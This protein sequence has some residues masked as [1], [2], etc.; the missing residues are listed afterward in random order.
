MIDGYYPVPYCDKD[1][2]SQQGYASGQVTDAVPSLTLTLVTAMDD[3]TIYDVQ[4]G[5]QYIGYAAGV[6]GTPTYHFSSVIGA[7]FIRIDGV[8]SEVGAN[9]VISHKED[10]SAACVPC[11][12]SFTNGATDTI[13]VTFTQCH[14]DADVANVKAWIMS[15]RKTN[16]TTFT[17]V[18]QPAAN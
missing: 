7:S 4:V 18:N 16:I 13:N 14:L 11:A 3:D 15:M 6:P 2:V 10:V 17:G 1:G 8:A 9:T 5:C 12:V